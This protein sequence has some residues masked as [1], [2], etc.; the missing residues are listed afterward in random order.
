MTLKE[1]VERAHAQ[2]R[3]SGW[4]DGGE[5]NIGEALMLIVTEAAE[6]MEVAR[7]FPKEMLC[8]QMYGEPPESKIKPVGFPSEIAD[9][10]IRVADL[11][12]YLGVDLEAAV[13]E[14]MTYNA[15]RPYRHGN[16]V[17]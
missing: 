15:T 8:A 11:C 9:I 13:I 7:R 2:S 12:G 6:A 10:V 5:R 3:K 4:Y 17:A 16:K 1:L 14:K